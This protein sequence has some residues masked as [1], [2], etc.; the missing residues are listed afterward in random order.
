[1]PPVKKDLIKTVKS[2]ELR[3]YSSQSL[4]IIIGLALILL[5]AVGT[6]IYFY[7]QYQRAQ[8]ELTKTTQSNEQAALIEEV[9]KLIVLPTNEQPTVATVSDVNRL[10]NQS[11]FIHARDGDK[12]LIYTKAQEAILYDPLA[13]KIV[14]VGP[15]SLTQVT[16]TPKGPTPTPAPIRVAV[17]NGTPTGGLA[18]KIGL[19]I[20]QKMPQATIVAKSDAKQNYSSTIVVDLT[21]KNQAAADALTELLGAKL[22]S[23]P[24]TEIKPKNADLVVI[25]GK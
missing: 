7:M 9:G 23:F 21:G 15:I 8:S 4:I 2:T 18:T 10:K 14:E 24:T 6:A 5:A 20:T 3:G 25:L 22:S 12:V 1:M 17:Y 13:N 19:E 16:P 11:F